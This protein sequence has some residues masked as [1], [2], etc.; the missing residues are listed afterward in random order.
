MIPCKED[1]LQATYL[2]NTYLNGLVMSFSSPDIIT[3]TLVTRVMAL[4]LP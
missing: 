3:C 4:E 1:V 2:Q